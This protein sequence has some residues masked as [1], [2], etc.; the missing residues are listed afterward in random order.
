MLREVARRL[1]DLGHGIAARLGG[2]EF[3]VIVDPLPDDDGSTLAVVA[4]TIA[5]RLAEPMRINGLRLDVTASVGL[6]R[7]GGGDGVASCEALLHAADQRMYR[8]KG[9][10]S[11]RLRAVANAR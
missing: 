2:D 3:V 7:H 9:R 11:P 8:E 10:H 5:A 4:K 1:T 6:S